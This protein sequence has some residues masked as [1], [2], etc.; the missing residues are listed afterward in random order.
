MVLTQG[1]MVSDGRTGRNL[2]LWDSAAGFILL[3]SRVSRPKA[4]SLPAL[5]N[6]MFVLGTN[7]IGALFWLLDYLQFH[8]NL[9]HLCFG[10]GELFP[11]SS[12]VMKPREE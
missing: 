10:G 8:K 3:R 7:E 6:V 5:I 2:S 9:V 12:E 11:G 1:Q 4:G